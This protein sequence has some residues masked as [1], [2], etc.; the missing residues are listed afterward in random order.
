MDLALHCLQLAEHVKYDQKKD[1][2]EIVAQVLTRE[3][4]SLAN[5][6]LGAEMEERASR[7]LASFIGEMQQETRVNKIREEKRKIAS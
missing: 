4:L 3:E 5:V 2:Y 7:S 1:Y 6:A